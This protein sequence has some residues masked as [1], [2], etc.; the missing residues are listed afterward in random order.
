MLLL[1][2]SGS[3]LCERQEEVYNF[4]LVEGA[5][6]STGS[7]RLAPSVVSV[8]LWNDLCASC[9]RSSLHTM[10]GFRGCG[11]Q[12]LKKSPFDIHNRACGAQLPAAE[13]L[14]ARANTAFAPPM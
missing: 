13:S 7:A 9:P 8:T 4:C 3:G 14:R 5:A 1:S 11:Q 6:P 12:C 10:E 2:G